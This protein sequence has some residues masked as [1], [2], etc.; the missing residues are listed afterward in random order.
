MVIR[1]IKTSDTLTFVSL[2]KQVEGSS[3]FMLWEEGEREVDTKRQQKMIEEIEN[4][5]NSM[6]FVAEKDKGLIGYLLAIGGSAKRNK[7]SAYLVVGVL[8]EFRSKGIGT[9][10]FEAVEK[11]AKEQ[12]IHRLELTVVTKNDSGVALYKKQGFEIEGVKRDSL[13]INGEFVDEFYMSKLL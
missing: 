8:K 3:K 1:K 2:I 4:S 10:L 11:W 12:S 5:E 9:L 13:Y 7:H 6:I